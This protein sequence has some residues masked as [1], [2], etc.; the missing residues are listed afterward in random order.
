MISGCRRD[1]IMVRFYYPRVILNKRKENRSYGPKMRDAVLITRKD[2][3]LNLAKIRS[4]RKPESAGRVQVI[5]VT[6]MEY[7]L[8]PTL[9]IFTPSKSLQAVLSFFKKGD[10]RTCMIRNLPDPNKLL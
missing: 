9:F 5:Q 7:S 8:F 10:Q 4:S 3:T 1:T 6:P 2:R